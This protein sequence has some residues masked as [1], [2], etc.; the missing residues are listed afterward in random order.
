MVPLKRKK[1]LQNADKK[2]LVKYFT[3]VNRMAKKD[4]KYERI[5][6]NDLKLITQYGRYKDIFNKTGGSGSNPGYKK[7]RLSS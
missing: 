1:F 6:K 3:L 4:K 2:E 7:N 5:L